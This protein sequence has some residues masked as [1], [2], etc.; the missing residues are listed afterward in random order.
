L[1]DDERF[2]HQGMRMVP[3]RDFRGMRWIAQIKQRDGTFARQTPLKAKHVPQPA[4]ET[5]E[6]CSRGTILDQIIAFEDAVRRH[7][8]NKMRLPGSPGNPPPDLS[9]RPYI[10]LGVG[11]HDWRPAIET[12]A[13]ETPAS[14]CKV[15]NGN[16]LAP[17]VGCLACLRTGLDHHLDP[18]PAKHRP[19]RVVKNRK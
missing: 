7:R 8:H 5:R 10:L 12:P 11:Y 19:P 3:D 18:V 13:G 2:S 6:R 1:W 17:G 16:P 9:P 15:C 14:K 4:D